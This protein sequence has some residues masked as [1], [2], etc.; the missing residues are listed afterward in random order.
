MRADSRGGWCRPL[1]GVRDLILAAGCGGWGAPR[2]ARALRGGPVLAEPLPALQTARMVRGAVVL[3]AWLKVAGAVR[4]SWRPHHVL[5]SCS[6]RRS[7]RSGESSAGHAAALLPGLGC[8]FYPLQ[9]RSAAA[10][11]SQNSDSAALHRPP[12]LAACSAGALLSL[13]TW[14][15]PCGCAAA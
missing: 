11:W 9:S 6:G 15:G 2:H 14:R 3:G 1:L 12:T 4:N 8:S 5:A 7:F 10:T 13:T